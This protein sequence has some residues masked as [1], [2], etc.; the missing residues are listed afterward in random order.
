[1]KKILPV[2][3]LITFGITTLPAQ[4]N[5]QITLKSTLQQQAIAWNNGNIDAFME[6]YWKSEKLQFIS[7][8]KVTYGWQNTLDNYKKGYPDKA[9]MGQLTFDVIDIK[10]LGRKSAS[11]TGKW[12]LKRDADKGDVGGHFLLLWQKIKGKWVIVADCTN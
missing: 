10:K 9:T 8:K 7:S 3:I 2:L 6:A 12:M 4:S 5:L 11:L 1:M